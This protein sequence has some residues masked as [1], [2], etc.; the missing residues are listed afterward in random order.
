MP[1]HAHLRASDA[2]RERVVERLREAAS[3]GRIGAD[4]LDDR[5][6]RALRALTYADLDATVV[7]LPGPRSGPGRAPRPRA[8]PTA[9]DWAWSTVRANP[10]VLLFMIPV[11][12]AAGAMLLAISITWLTL[13]AVAMILTGGHHRGHL[14]HRRGGWTLMGGP[15][16]PRRDWI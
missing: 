12:I 4:E 15:G 8:R 10:C 11:A 1:R 14:G 3:E 13:M 9:T 6:S 16:G 2:D 7:D 5:V